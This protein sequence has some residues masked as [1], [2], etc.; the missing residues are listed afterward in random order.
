MRAYYDDVREVHPNRGSP[1][2]SYA[3]LTTVPPTVTTEYRVGVSS[4]IYGGSP[5]TKPCALLGLLK[6]SLGEGCYDAPQL[7]SRARGPP[8]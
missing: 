7:V 1:L 8:C 4:T 5:L 2:P 3:R 6:H